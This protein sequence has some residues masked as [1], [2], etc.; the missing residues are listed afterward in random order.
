M[1][2]NLTGSMI[3]FITGVV[4]P[5]AVL[6]I[7]S[8]LEKKKV[9]PDMVKETLRVSELVTTKI[10]HIKVGKFCLKKIDIVNFIL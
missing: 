3:A 10:E 2:E 9:K 1:F 4:G 8:K 6:Y 7:K 5:I